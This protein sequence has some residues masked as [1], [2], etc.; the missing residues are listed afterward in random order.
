MEF[1]GFWDVLLSFFQEVYY[2]NPKADMKN[3]RVEII[4]GKRQEKKQKKRKKQQRIG[5]LGV[6]VLAVLC[7]GYLLACT[8]VEKNMILDEVWVNNTEVGGLTVEQA[9]EKIQKSFEE[10]YKNMSLTVQ[11]NNENYTVQMYDSLAMDAEGAAKKAMEYGHGNF[12]TRGAALFKAK[13][14]GETMIQNPQIGDEVKLSE[15]I[16]ASGLSAINTTVQ[17]TYEVSGNTLILH[18]GKSGV[19]VD[20]EKLTE[21]IKKAVTNAAYSATIESPMLVGQVEATDIQAIYDKIHTKKS[22]ATLDPDKD[23]KIVKS[24]KGISFDVESAKATFDAAAEGEDVTIPLT[25]KK[26]K[27]S[28]KKLKKH[29]FKDKL[30][31][32]TT[33]VSGSSARVS[34]VKLAADTLDGTILLPG[35]T[36]SYNDTLGERTTA[37]G[38]QAAP[39]Y[40]NG[41]SVQEVGGGICQ[42]SSTLYKATLLSDLKIVEH[43]NHS[44]VS[45]YIGIG[46]D[47][48][49]SWG[50]PDYQFKNDTDYPIKIVASYS[51][52][53]VTCSIYGAKLDDTHVEMTAETLQVNSSGTVYQDDPDMEAGT[54]T[55]VS[56]GHDG[57]VVQTYRNIYDKNGKKIST[58][59][60]AYCVYRKK[61]RVVRVGTKQSP[62][63]ETT[64][65]NGTGVSDTTTEAAQ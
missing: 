6:C 41:E 51:G 58:T 27:I 61:D 33:N 7:I 10:E 15:A 28:T 39:A 46:M 18:K 56:S 40:S 14:F 52:G 4:M 42:V 48:T 63:T 36:F 47:A 49:V 60:E 5:L 9:T 65:G 1:V 21:E 8:M 3:K 19:S 13:L 64:E 12:L 29:L 23:Y 37:R 38:Y 30:G 32:C 34:N 2:N 55:V 22:N 31:S 53:Q 20:K 25:V 16:D 24:V 57:Y 59:K 45:S 50:G 43:H 54:S 44:Y 62:S 17:T 35:E 11:A 26:P